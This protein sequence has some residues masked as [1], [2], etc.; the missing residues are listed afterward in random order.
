MMPPMRPQGPVIAANAN[1]PFRVNYFTHTIVVDLRGGELLRGRK[2][3][4]G[5]RLAAPSDMLL[6]DAEGNLVVRDELDD[7]P[8]CGEVAGNDTP[9]EFVLPARPKAAHGGAPG[10]GGPLDQMPTPREKPKKTSG[11]S[12]KTGGNPKKPG[13]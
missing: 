1:R 5:L 11:K 9:E 7:L 10:K 8:A 12:G 2:G 13:R 6:Q 4:N 3:G